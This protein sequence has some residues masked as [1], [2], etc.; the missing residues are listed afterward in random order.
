[1]HPQV[2]AAQTDVRLA[3]EAD[4]ETL[5]ATFPRLC[6]LVVQAATLC[7]VATRRNDVLLSGDLAQ[8]HPGS[9]SLVLSSPTEDQV[10][11]VGPETLLVLRPIPQVVRKVVCEHLLRRVRL[12]GRLHCVNAGHHAVVRKRRVVVEVTLQHLTN[13]SIVEGVQVPAVEM[14]LQLA[15]GVAP[16]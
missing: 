16:L 3:Q 1:M 14:G 9:T 12:R 11:A 5:P 4:V 13:D 15:P 2:S 10:P 6:V 7:V 8:L